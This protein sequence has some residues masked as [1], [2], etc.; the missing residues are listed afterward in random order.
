MHIK[1]FKVSENIVIKLEKDPSGKI[2]SNVYVGGKRILNC[3]GIFIRNPQLEERLD[4]ISS[5]D[6]VAA[7]MKSDSRNERYKFNNKNVID[8][9]TEF[10]GHCTNNKI[11]QM[12][13]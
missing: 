11:R 5:I 13:N 6:E 4:D 3:K 8:P 7:I 1:E 9:E 2:F 10:W 12:K